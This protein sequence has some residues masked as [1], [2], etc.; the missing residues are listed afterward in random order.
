MVGS[1]STIRILR[2]PATTDISPPKPTCC[3]VS[4]L[5]RPGTWNDLPWSFD[6]RHQPVCRSKA[7]GQIVF[8]QLMGTRQTILPSA[9]SQVVAFNCVSHPGPGSPSNKKYDAQNS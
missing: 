9:S 3:K 7:Q 4:C 5:I 2:P 1:S 8:S 6:I